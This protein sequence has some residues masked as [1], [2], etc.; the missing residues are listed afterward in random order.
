MKVLI[1]AASKYGST[2]EIADAIAETLRAD[3]LEPTVVPAEKAG[4]VGAFDAV[5]VGS[6]VYGGYWLGSARNFVESNQ[7]ALA[8]RPVWLFSSGPIGDPLRPDGLPQDAAEIGLLAGARGHEV[9]AG[10]LDLERV[11][12]D[13][14][15]MMIERH[16][17]PGDFRNWAKI[18][19]WATEIASALKAKASEP[20]GRA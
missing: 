20:A 5:V 10:L 3:G 12:A 15:L 19:A 11:D 16:V 6:A 14:R 9:F 4:D 1:T 8:A 13:E 2:T 17:R 7:E 18:R